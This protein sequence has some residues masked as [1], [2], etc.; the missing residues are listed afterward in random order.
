MDISNFFDKK[1]A[2]TGE[3]Q[4][5]E[6]EEEPDDNLTEVELGNELEEV[7]RDRAGTEHSDA[8]SATVPG[9]AGKVTDKIGIL[10]TEM[11]ISDRL[12][13]VM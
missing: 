5:G 6:N 7:S 8:M 1:N 4:P 11:D 13:S 3:I 2:S 10:A 12:T 9:P